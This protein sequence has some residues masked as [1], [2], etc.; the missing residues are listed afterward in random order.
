[1]EVYMVV[2]R[3][4]TTIHLSAKETSL[5]LEVKK[6]IEGILKVKPEDQMLLKHQ[7]EMD[8]E[9]SLSYYN[10][11]SQT[12]RAHTPATLGLCLRDPVIFASLQGLQTACTF[13]N[14]SVFLI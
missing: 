13:S 3:K 12:A 1:M 9:K 10:L 14:A 6:M 4:K 2:R 11:N 7:T 5:V 8:D